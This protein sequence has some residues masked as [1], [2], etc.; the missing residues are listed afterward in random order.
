MFAVSHSADLGV[1]RADVASFL[2][3]ERAAGRACEDFGAILPPHQHDAALRWQRRLAETGFAG[4]HWPLEYGGGGLSQAHSIIWY[5]ECARAQVA[6]YL[7]LQGIVLAGEAILRSGTSAQKQRFLAPTLNGDILWCQLFGE[8]EAGSDLASL[9]TKAQIDGERYILNGQKVWSSNGQ[10]AQFGILMARTDPDAPRHKGISFFLLDME[11]PGVDVR[12][13]KQMTGDE[14]FCEVFFDDVEMPAD[15]LLGAPHD[16]WRVAMDVLGD[17]RGSFG[18]AGVISL[19]QRLAGIAGM[20]A[21]ADT[22]AKDQLAS[23]LGRGHALKTLLLRSSDNPTMAPAVKVVRSELDVDVNSLSAGLRGAS[24][25]LAGAE[26]DTFL[27]APGMRVAGGT[28]EIQR[29]IIGERILGLPREPNP[30]S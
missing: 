11:L 17:E 3:Q 29:N 14:E 30:T 10:F 8:P 28:S 7:N 21:G 15:A 22:L 16:G 9:Q 5:E 26:T 25:M 27:Y 23:L 24:A 2:G 18:A 13:L 1:F 12:P 20:A 6:P 4:L 19:D